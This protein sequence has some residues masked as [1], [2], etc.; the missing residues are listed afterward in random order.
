MAVADWLVDDQDA[1]D[2]MEHVYADL[3]SGRT[4]RAAVR[5]AQ[6]SLASGARHPLSWAAFSLLGDPEVVAPAATTSTARRP[7]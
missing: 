4:A 5:D 3:A 7:A 1:A 2:F 6:R